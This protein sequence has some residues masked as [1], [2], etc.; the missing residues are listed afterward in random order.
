MIRFSVLGAPELRGDDASELRAVLT[1]PR[2]LALLTYLA[3]ARPRGF[4][5]RDTLV[6]LFWPEVGHEQARNSLRQAVHRLR[7]ALGDN[8]IVNRGGEELGIETTR[9]SCDAVTFED[10]LDRGDLEGALALY[11]GD[12]LPGFYLSDAEEFERWLDAERERL[13]RRAS[14]AMWQ[15]A[16]AEARLGRAAAATL[17]ARRADV[18]TPDDESS[19]RRLITLLANSG[20]RTGAMRT[21]EAFA[22]RLADDFEL[23]PSAET[24][25]L[26]SNLRTTTEATVTSAS[27]ATE[28]R[29][30]P[31]FAT[32]E[33]PSAPPSP[34]VEAAPSEQRA[35]SAGRRRTW[36]RSALAIAAATAALT[37]GVEWSK[38]NARLSTAQRGLAVFPFSV[39]SS[40]ELAYLSE[41]MV[42]L[43]SAKLEGAPG[44]RSIDPRSVI[45]AVGSVQ[46]QDF[47]ASAGI[48]RQLGAQWAIT[49]EVVEIAGRLQLSA[50]LYNVA[51]TAREVT[52][53]NVVGE[54]TALFQLVDDLAGRLLAG[55]VSGRDTSLTRLAALTTHSLP[56]L[57]AFLKGEQALRGGH[58]AQAVAAF[59]EAASLDTAFALALYR[60]AV[61]STWSQ[62][63]PL[64]P[65]ALAAAAARHADRL[66]PL[67]RDLLR[68]YDAYKDLRGD[69]A[70]RIYRAIAD[71]HPDNVEA[72]L[73]MGEVWFHY[74]AMRGRAPAEARPAFER[75][76][77]LDP[78][79][80]HAIIHL[81][82][83]SALEG[84]YRDLDSLARLYMAYHADAE[85][86]TEIRVLRA[87]TTDSGSRAAAIRAT[88]E[89]EDVQSM[90]LLLAAV[91]Y[92]QDF[93]GGTDM[94]P[95]FTRRVRHANVE[96]F[97]H[98]VLTDMPVARGMRDPALVRAALG[99]ATDSTWA[100]ETE[101]LIAAEPFFAISR[102]RVDE[103]H[104][105][106]LNARWYAPV[107]S[108]AYP[109]APRMKVRDD[110]YREYLIALLDVRRGDTAAA[111]ARARTLGNLQDTT[112]AVIGRALSH[113]I[114]A[115]LARTRGQ[116][117]RVLD[118]L[119]Q[120]SFD[121]RISVAIEHWGIRER[122]LYAEALRQTGRERD[123]LQWYDSFVSAWDLPFIAPAHFRAAEIH[124]HLGNPAAARLHYARFATQWRRADPE[125]QPLVQQARQ[126]L[127]RLPVPAGN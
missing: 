81:I 44:F 35:P 39:R 95:A 117:Q 85:R 89:S 72:W 119:D 75:A 25:A 91:C 38:A 14:T 42:D 50:T 126:A 34:P 99:V 28:R 76:L 123:A 118:E 102:A 124:E 127:E 101:T 82:R 115:E 20:D 113:G 36:I 109:V 47:T 100:L 65:P 1:Q 73:M 16:E 97:T 19:V 45:A 32:Y 15:H 5:R 56:A 18:M 74:N 52:S 43:L 83:L 94:I 96:R 23:A 93:T 88:E 13:R 27:T 24:S 26:V 11:R 84:R 58:D 70:E 46:R 7:Q 17:W 33:F 79:N 37:A 31:V 80:A 103:T 3:I 48:A 49:G 67:L 66:P 8:I 108:P 2:L 116:W 77:R 114:R 59:Q 68:G 98:A 120:F 69:E 111:M 10:A 78:G 104:S 125:L 106:L 6:A 29:M 71:S 61:A 53:A 21:Y 107:G 60:L 9:F 4:H 64:D 22:K 40:D 86:L 51:G 105:R 41:G 54:T 87:F 55:I 121:T 122:F 30:E 112:V 62:V 90:S 12:L 63:P 110:A 92:A 57:K